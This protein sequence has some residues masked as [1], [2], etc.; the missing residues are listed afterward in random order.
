M[1]SPHWGET[2]SGLGSLDGNSAGDH[3]LA[4]HFGRRP[5]AATPY[6]FSTRQ[7]ARLLVL[8]SR[9]KI[10]SYRAMTTVGS[11]SLLPRR[12]SVSYQQPY[13]DSGKGREQNP[14]LRTTP[15]RRAQMRI[16][17]YRRLVATILGLDVVTVGHDLRARRIRMH[18]HA[19]AA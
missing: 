8:R 17:A 6:P 16:L 10:A 2:E 14:W 7:Y 18:D 11:R 3:D 13:A 12:S 1:T 15:R 4:F 19:K 5:S 9:S